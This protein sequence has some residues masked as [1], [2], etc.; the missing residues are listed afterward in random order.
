[1]RRLP[2]VLTALAVA[3]A[4]AGCGGTVGAGA[5][6]DEPPD[7]AK[8]APPIRALDGAPPKGLQEMFA[9]MTNPDATEV[10]GVDDSESGEAPS[11]SEDGDGGGSGAG[12]DVDADGSVTD[13]SGGDEAPGVDEYCVVDSTAGGESSDQICTTETPEERQH[14]QEEMQ[15]WLDAIRPAKDSPPRVVAALARPGKEDLLFT[16]WKD[17]AGKLCTAAATAS[18]E[19]LGAIPGGPC[20][21][22]PHCEDSC[23][24]SMPNE[25]WEFALT[26]TVPVDGKAVR[27]T[28]ANG[29]TFRYPLEGPT[30]PGTDR[31]V[32]MTEL[33]R[34]DWRH[35]EVLDADGTVLGEQT[36]PKAQAASEDCFT[37]YVPQASGEQPDESAVADLERCMKEAGAAD[38]WSMTLSSSTTDTP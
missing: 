21:P 38:G 19:E 28:V 2:G 22:Y 15:R 14:A 6:G 37:R 27:V 18:G 36:M 1:M 8:E 13:D 25:Q 20:A 4:A 17:D 5:P 29:T 32:F 11:D 16:A 31:R 33:G 26:G 24:Q 10:A 9:P 35:I 23:L 34:A 3:V 12:G 7:V 30:V